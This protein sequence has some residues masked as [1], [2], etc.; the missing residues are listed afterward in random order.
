MLWLCLNERKL[1][2]LCI[3]IDNVCNYI[4]L[5]VFREFLLF[6]I[7]WKKC[8]I[9]DLEFIIVFFIDFILIVCLIGVEKCL[10]I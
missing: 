9:K 7:F 3:C 5:F 6:G 1:W 2:K 10:G 8:N 4:V